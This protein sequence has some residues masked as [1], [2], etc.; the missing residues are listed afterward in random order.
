MTTATP[1]CRRRRGAADGADGLRVALVVLAGIAFVALFF[2]DA[3]PA[4]NRDRRSRWRIV[5]S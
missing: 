4:V 3:S 5:R 1:T 2:T